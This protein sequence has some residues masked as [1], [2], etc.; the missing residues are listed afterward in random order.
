MENSDKRESTA[1]CPFS[2][3]PRNCI[4]QHFALVEARLILG[5]LYKYYTFDLVPGFEIE[6][7]PKIVLKTKFGAK[8]IVRKR[9]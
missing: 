7:D 6:P 2:L 8:L 5:M 3:G 1:F 9:K 4:G